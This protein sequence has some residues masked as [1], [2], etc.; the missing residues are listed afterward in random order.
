MTLFNQIIGILIAEALYDSYDSMPLTVVFTETELFSTTTNS[1]LVRRLITDQGG[2]SLVKM[3]GQVSQQGLSSIISI[4][5]STRNNLCHLI[6]TNDGR[7]LQ[8]RVCE[9]TK[10]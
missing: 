2:R 1:R 10:R 9:K 8:L 4:A 6:S 7:L 3:V 5:H